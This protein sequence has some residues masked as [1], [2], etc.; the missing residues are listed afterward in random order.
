MVVLLFVLTLGE[1]L[2]I[3]RL[4]RHILTLVVSLSIVV[5]WLIL[6]IASLL[7]VLRLLLLLR[8]LLGIA[9]IV[10]LVA[11]LARSS[12]TSTTSLLVVSVSVPLAS[13][14]VLAR[15]KGCLTV[16]LHFGLHILK[17][18]IYRNFLTNFILQ[19]W[20]WHFIP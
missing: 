6:A 9:W 17:V 10:S 14:A 8:V 3:G 7:L 13:L 18:N 4:V 15:F 2:R 1:E 11:S 16:F 20:E 12:T 19:I 5:P